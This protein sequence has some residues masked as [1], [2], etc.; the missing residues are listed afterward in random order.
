MSLLNKFKTNSYCVGGRHYSGTVNIRGAITSKGTKMLK[1]YCVLC[2][3]N[4]SMTVSD[5]TIEAE[6]LK[7][8]FKSVGRA[9]V[10]FGKKVANN[11]VKALEIAR[12]GSAA[13]SRNP[14]AALS[15]TPDLNKFATT[16]LASCW[17][18]FSIV[19]FMDIVICEAGSLMDVVMVSSIYHN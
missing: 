18:C 8:F 17:C 19:L 12:I 6:G 3:R 2:R 10:N 15:A 7:D 11:P 13:A 4:K 16:K 5:A 14:R 1:T 9:T